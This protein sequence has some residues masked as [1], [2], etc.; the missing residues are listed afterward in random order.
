[1]QARIAF[2]YGVRC[3]GSSFSKRRPNCDCNCRRR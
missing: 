1:V 3:S 2:S